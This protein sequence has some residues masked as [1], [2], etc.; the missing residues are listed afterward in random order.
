MT[1]A[2]HASAVPSAQAKPLLPAEA[3]TLQRLEGVI[4]RGMKVFYEVGTALSEI[5]DSRLYRATHTSFEDYLR[6]RW[7][8]SRQFAW[9]QIEASKVVNALSTRVDSAGTDETESE[10]ERTILPMVETQ[11]RPLRTLEPAQ[12]REAWDSA[13][14][15]AGGTQPTT[16]QV[17]E[18]V[19]KMTKASKSAQPETP[20]DAIVEEHDGEPDAESEPS[21]LPDED[22]VKTLPARSKLADNVRR[23]FDAEAIAFRLITPLRREYRNRCKRLANAAKKEGRHIGPWLSRHDH[24]LRLPDPS[25]WKACEECGGSGNVELVGKCPA[26]KGHAYHVV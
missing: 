22:W 17:K 23:W 18:A 7:G 10:P 2:I 9:M 3:A 25:Q 11:T 20:E 14:A 24:Y 15:D 5:R 6:E 8:F 26:C 21:D 1:I 12:Q 13:V 16:A 4:R 19:A